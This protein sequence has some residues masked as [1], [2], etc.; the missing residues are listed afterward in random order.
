[1]RS[2]VASI[3]ALRFAITCECIALGALLA[4][5]AEP[6]WVAL[7]TLPEQPLHLEASLVATVAT[8]RTGEERVPC[9]NRATN[10]TVPPRVCKRR[11]LFGLQRA[12]SG[13]HAQLLAT[14]AT[15]LC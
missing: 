12:T 15:G 10:Y 1:M 3:A 2:V 7:A 5:L 4:I 11:R 6:C 13:K 14:N 9:I 8:F